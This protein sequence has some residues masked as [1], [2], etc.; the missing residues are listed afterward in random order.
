M[1][2]YDY[3]NARLRAMK[4]RLL[5]RNDLEKLAGV[6]SLRAFIAELAKTAYQRPVETALARVSGLESI[7]LALHNDLE[8]TFQKIRGLYRDRAGEMVGLYL[9]AYDVRNLQ[10]VLR[11][12]SKNASPDEILLTLL[13]AGELTHEILADLSRTADPRAAIDRLATMAL[14]FASPLLRLR[15]ERPGAGTPEMELVLVQ[16]YYQDAQDLLRRKQE[17]AGALFSALQLD[18]DIT[19][20]HTVMRF[21]YGAGERDFLEAWLGVQDVRRI[22]VGPGKLPFDQLAAAAGMESVAGAVETLAHTPY[23]DPLQIALEA[24]QSAGR[25]SVFEN[26]LNR[27]RLEQLA[28]W[29]G[30]DPLGSGVVLGYVALKTAEVS[31][32]Q[33]IAQAINLGL[34]AG[35]IRSELVFAR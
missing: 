6:G 20:L 30:K 26:Q 5:G 12:L 11:G 10:A 32:L 27:F 14:P 7:V 23:A 13:P 15:A 18:A 2:G 29:I 3:G 28:R 17:T 21:A 4:S 16:W 24:Y 9:R 34:S 19:N 8:F 31:N 35:S 22:F 1:A 25:L 33:W